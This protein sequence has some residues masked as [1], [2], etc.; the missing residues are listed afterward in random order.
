MGPDGKPLPQPNPKKLFPRLYKTLLVNPDGS[1]YTI[2]Q[3]FPHRILTLPLDLDTLSAEE[4][5]RRLK[6][7]RQQEAP[8]FVEEEDIDLG[9]DQSDYKDLINR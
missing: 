5:S 9:F 1:T 6:K 2:R 7:R 3:S 8:V 4:R